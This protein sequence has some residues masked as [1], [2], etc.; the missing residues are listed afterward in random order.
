MTA[1][2]HSHN[3]LIAEAGESAPGIPLAIA[4]GTRISY[5]PEAGTEEILTVEDQPTP[6]SGWVYAID[7][8]GYSKLVPVQLATVI[9][10]SEATGMPVTAEHIHQLAGANF[11][12]REAVLVRDERLEDGIAVIPAVTAAE[13]GSTVLLSGADFYEA[14]G[15]AVT[16]SE[17]EQIAA[18][19]NTR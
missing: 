11:G 4:P 2:P 15:N 12:R 5:G 7:S 16:D 3:R 14:W 19:L 18:E 9:E 6:G 10:D 1:T 8:E 17:A 13:R